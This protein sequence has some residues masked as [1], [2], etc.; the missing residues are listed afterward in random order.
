MIATTVGLAALFDALAAPDQGPINRPWGHSVDNSI[1]ER[2]LADAR[3]PGNQ[4]HSAS[5]PRGRGHEG[6]HHAEFFV[7]THRRQRIFD[8]AYARIDFR[9]HALFDA[10]EAIALPANRFDKPGGPRVVS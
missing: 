6:I 8:H 7:A 4:G 3:F 10:D 9:T 5:T 2:S 1:H